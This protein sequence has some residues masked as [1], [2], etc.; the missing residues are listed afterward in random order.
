MDFTK[1]L[2]L[3]FL[4]MMLF[5]SQNI[6]SQY[7]KSHYIPPITTTGNGAAN[8]LDQYLY[9]STPS[10]IPVN[11]VIKPMGGSDITG[12]VSNSNPWA[13]YIGNGTNTNLIVTAGSLDGIA[14]NNKG[15][16]I[17]SEEVKNVSA[18]LFSGSY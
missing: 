7:S 12:T 5:I 4:I 3:A 10:E 16:I 1:I 18:S 8:P 6:M 13:Y 15:F 2:R 11:V 14:Y 17:D 9:I